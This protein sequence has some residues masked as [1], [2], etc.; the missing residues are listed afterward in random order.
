MVQF[1]ALR[2]ARRWRAARTARHV[3][4]RRR[5][6]GSPG[7][8]AIP[9]PQGTTWLQRRFDR[10]TYPL[11]TEPYIIDVD[12]T[13]KPLYGEQVGAVVRYD[14]QKKGRPCHVHH[15]DLRAGVRL[16]MRAGRCPATSTGANM[17][18]PDCRL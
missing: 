14:P 9:E 7:A 18:R 15:S 11:L 17:P 2:A 5:R 13:V 16:V 4:D 12:T 10:C 3:E 6:P 1:Q 8:A